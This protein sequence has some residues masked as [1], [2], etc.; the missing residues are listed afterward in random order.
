V[1]PRRGRSLF[2]PIAGLF[3]LAVVVGTLLQAFIVTAVLRPLETRDQR[4]RAELTAS[5]IA[6]EIAALPEPPRAGALDALLA[7]HGSGLGP[8][9]PWLLYRGRDGVI[10]STPPDLA[11]YLPHLLAGDGIP[12]VGPPDPRH[13]GRRGRLEPI[14][15]RSIV[16]GSEVLGEI[17]MV[18]PVRAVGTFG[19]RE[20]RTTLLF[21]PIAALLSIGV[22]LV[23]VRLLVRRLRT[24]ELLAARVAEGDL[25]VRIADTSGDEIGRLAERLDRMAERL[26]DAQGRIEATERQRRQL[27][28]DITHEL[29][30]PLT[31][32]RGYAETLLDPGVSVSTEERT[33]YVRG[34]LEESRRLDRMIRDLFDLARLEAGAAPL[35]K[36][37]LDWAALCRNTLERFEPRFRESGLTL[38][39]K[40][41][42][43]Q[44]WIEADGHRMEEVLENLLGNALR[45]VPDGGHVELVLGWAERL[46]AG[47]RLTVSDDGPGLPPDE[48]PHVF[49]RFYR[50]A[51]ARTGARDNGGSG[52]GL[53]IVREIVERHGGSV[54]AEA[55]APH[56]LKFVVELPAP[57]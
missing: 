14:A 38:G 8:F 23:I 20:W 57:A 55:H 45:Y 43:E 6:A 4:A 42:V 39:W 22:G 15:R 36:E 56:G 27:F 16:H 40:P 9:P 41:A 11:R 37:R 26:A 54:R 30:T 50:G 31:S 7:R 24:L 33:R 25:G 34:V 12:D 1:S 51:A 5:N 19:F 3:L 52:L 46:P 49:E 18:R 35:E 2:W 44:A 48:L 47:F 32:V 21:L 13:P 29:A 17:I 10:V 28:A 53:A